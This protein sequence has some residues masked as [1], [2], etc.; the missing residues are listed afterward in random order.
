M[1]A[2]QPSSCD[3]MVVKD[4]PSANKDVVTEQVSSGEDVV[5]DQLLLCTDDALYSELGGVE[6]Q[7]SR[8]KDVVKDQFSSGGDIVNDLSWGNT[9]FVNNPLWSDGDVLRYP[10]LSDKHVLKCPL[11]CDRVAVS[12]GMQCVEVNN[13]VLCNLDVVT[14]RCNTDAEFYKR[15]DPACCNFRIMNH[16]LTCKVLRRR[17]GTSEL[18]SSG[19]CDECAAVTCGGPRVKD[20]DS[21]A[22]WRRR[23]RCCIVWCLLLFLLGATPLASGDM[24]PQTDISSS[25][26]ERGKLYV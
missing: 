11:S 3:G 4:L 16:S 14:E 2:W 7:F 20:Q 12:S 23:R 15:D 25:G 17:S 8:H 26:A 9:Y 10:L 5:K 22:S 24:S 18:D 13:S 1:G 6:N 21:S 19:S